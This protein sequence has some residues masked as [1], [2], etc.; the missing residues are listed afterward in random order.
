MLVTA[1]RGELSGVV[2]R[3][4]WGYDLQNRRSR[5]RDRGTEESRLRVG[6]Q[7]VVSTKQ[8]DKS[9]VSS[10]VKDMAL[11]CDN[12]NMWGRRRGV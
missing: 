7:G 10:G 4:Q 9:S 1:R 12:P 11:S 6:I 8:A 5:G 3:I 2:E